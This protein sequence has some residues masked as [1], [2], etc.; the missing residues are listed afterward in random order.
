MHDTAIVLTVP[1][2]QVIRRSQSRQRSAVRPISAAL[3]RR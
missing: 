1:S 2:L 3:A